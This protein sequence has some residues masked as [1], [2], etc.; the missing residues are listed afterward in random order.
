MLPLLA[1]LAGCQTPTT[2]TEVPASAAV[3]A[4]TIGHIRPSRRDTCE[5]RRQIAEQSSRIET[6]RTGKI[7]EYREACKPETKGTS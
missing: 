7:V 1:A 6:I 3:V 5:T 4:E 2:A